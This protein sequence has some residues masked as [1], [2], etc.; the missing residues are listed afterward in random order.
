MTI[1][2]SERSTSA[3]RRDAHAPS[4]RDVSVSYRRVGTL[5]SSRRDPA[6]SETTYLIKTSGKDVLQ[7]GEKEYFLW[8]LLDGTNS[9]A[10]IQSKFAGRFGAPLTPEQF[11]SFVEQLVACGAIEVQKPDA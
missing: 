7:F 10:E 6:T 8:R 2:A 1:D 3:G 4:R 9:T 11:D 5:G